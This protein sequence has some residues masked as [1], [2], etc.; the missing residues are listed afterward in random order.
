M[1]CSRDHFDKNWHS[2][3]NAKY[4]RNQN[5]PESY[6]SVTGDL[7]NHLQNNELTAPFLFQPNSRYTL[8]SIFSS[9]RFIFRG[10]C[11]YM[12]NKNIN[13]SS[14]KDIGR[15]SM[16]C[17]AIR[18]YSFTFVVWWL[19]VYVLNLWLRDYIRI[20][21]RVAQYFNPVSHYFQGSRPNSILYTQR[22]LTAFQKPVFN[23]LIRRVPLSGNC[24]RQLLQCT[25]TPLEIT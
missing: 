11:L 20:A 1:V 19:Q 10:T 5:V 2:F 17:K 13:M 3:L 16:T 6:M 14:R 7:C 23:Y 8:I 4:R 12:C 21:A 18:D 9:I 22:F 25:H 15:S 24:P